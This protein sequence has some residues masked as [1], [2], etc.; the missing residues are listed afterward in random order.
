MFLSFETGD[1]ETVEATFSPVPANEDVAAFTHLTSNDGRRLYIYSSWTGEVAVVD[2]V[3]RR[4]ERIFPLDHAGLRRGP[5]QARDMRLS[6]DGTLLYI[7]DGSVLET[8][9]IPDMMPIWV[10]DLTTWRLEHRLD[11]PG[12]IQSLYPAP[13]GETLLVVSH[14]VDPSARVLTNPD[15]WTFR[16]LTFETGGYE[17]IDSLELSD[18]IDQNASFRLTAASDLYRATYGHAPVIDGIEPGDVAEYTTLP[19]ARV[20]VEDERVP[21]GVITPV[22]L[23]FL[24]PATG[25]ALTGPDPRVRYTPGDSLLLVFEQPGQKSIVSVSA[26]IAPGQQAGT[27]RLKAEGYWDARIIVGDDES[28]FTLI[29]QDVFQGMPTLAGDDGRAYALRLDTTPAEP[30]RAGEIMVQ[31]TFVDAATGDPLPEDVLLVDGMP[32]ELRV[33]MT[34]PGS[35]IQD[36][37]PVGHGIYEGMI[38]IERP[39]VWSI[40][41][42]FR[43]PNSS[44][45]R[46]VRIEMGTMEIVEASTPDAQVTP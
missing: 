21:V 1:V 17:L 46:S 45:P 2:L 18:L 24:D 39:A 20:V 23:E 15:Q 9:R 12:F 36:L 44:E 5:I 42:I 4:L 38:S 8:S 28:G 16:L 6:H 25:R 43:Q 33:A 40:S 41:L 34:G 13:D 35:S 3:G 7:I 26:E 29:L 10:V 22:E 30:V 19:R 31:A 37:V 27:V 14:S 32:E 11:I